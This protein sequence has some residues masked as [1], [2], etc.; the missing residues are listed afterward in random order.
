MSFG[1]ALN[2]RNLFSTVCLVFCLV[3]L[4]VCVSR[5]TLC[6]VCLKYQGSHYVGLLVYSNVLQEKGRCLV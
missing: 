2:L 1:V 5:E 6:E 4:L 3:M